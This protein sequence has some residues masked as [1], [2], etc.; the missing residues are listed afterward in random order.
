MTPL[1]TRNGFPEGYPHRQRMESELSS[2][3]ML[4][5][6]SYRSGGVLLIKRLWRNRTERR[7][8]RALDLLAGHFR[9]RTLV[10]SLRSRVLELTLSSDI[11]HIGLESGLSVRISQ[12]ACRNGQMANGKFA[13]WRHEVKCGISKLLICRIY[14][15]I[16][17][18]FF[19]TFEPLE[20][21]KI[22]EG[23]NDRGI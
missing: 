12:L 14:F 15:F 1:F 9:K 19:C 6:K 13:V 16:G 5:R 21:I 20:K 22:L 11:G 17:I 4:G 23:Y 3:W 7:K 2:M 18:Q 8:R 10:D